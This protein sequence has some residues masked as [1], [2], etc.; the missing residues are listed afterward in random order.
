[1]SVRKGSNII[2]IGNV[3]VDG[4][5]TS[6]NSN[7]SLQAIGTKNKNTE[8]SVVGI[9]DWVGTKDEYTE[10]NVAVL[11]PDW[12]CFITDDEEIDV[13]NYYTKTATEDRFAHR[14]ADNFTTNGQNFLTSLG[15]P[16]ARSESV[17]LLSSGSTYTAP[18]NGLFCFYFKCQTSGNK[19][20]ITNDTRYTST[21]MV[22]TVMSG[23]I[24]CVSHW[25]RK[26]DVIKLSWQ[27]SAINLSDSSA[28]F[29][30]AVGNPGGV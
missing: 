24:Q 23:T 7:H 29:I 19:I 21:L 20:T 2:A 11:H 27:S 14:D 28:D 13:E 26:G 4:D 22:T 25:C 5:T 8:S 30:Y 16:S 1:M 6:F 12:I 10:Q 17:T 18:A 3:Q 15:M 9:Y